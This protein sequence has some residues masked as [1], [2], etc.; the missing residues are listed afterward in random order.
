VASSEAPHA[1]KGQIVSQQ[2]EAGGVDLFN[3]V[4]FDVASKL[5]LNLP[6]PGLQRALE[7]VAVDRVPPILT[8]ADVTSILAARD[9]R[10]GFKS[11]DE[12][13]QLLVDLLGKQAGDEAWFGKP[14]VGTDP[15]VPALRDLVSVYS[16]PRLEG[17]G[18]TSG[19]LPLS[20]D[21]PR[22]ALPFVKHQTGARRS[23]F[24]HAVLSNIEGAPIEVQSDAVADVVEQT[25][26]SPRRAA[27][28]SRA[29][30]SA[31]PRQGPAAARRDRGLPLEVGRRP[32]AAPSTRRKRTA[33]A[34]RHLAA[35][36]R[37]SSRACPTASART[38]SAR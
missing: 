33:G 23:R 29:R 20:Y 22:S 30:R 13:R 37:L 19:T 8:A 31:S 18:S 16:T 32:P 15:A 38:T 34:F 24:L 27:R 6:T 21:I 9:A 26:T 28:P 10:G 7:I 36:Q 35:V 14:A 17:F 2:N 25:P 4:S 11:R 12:V 5:D 3:V 1:A